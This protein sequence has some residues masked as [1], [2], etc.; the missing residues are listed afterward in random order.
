MSAVMLNFGKKRNARIWNA[1][2]LKILRILST[3]W[4]LET[5]DMARELM[6]TRQEN[7]SSDTQLDKK[8]TPQKQQ[9]FKD[10]WKKEGGKDLK[11]HG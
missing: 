6:K 10:V 5:T 9:L 1:V 4:V 8:G 11:E 3:D 7:Q 2:L